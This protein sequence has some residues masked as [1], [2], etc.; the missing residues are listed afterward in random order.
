M[1]SSRIRLAIIGIGSSGARV[2]L[3]AFA[4]FPDVDVL[5]VVAPDESGEGTA[6][7]AYG[8]ERVETDAECLVNDPGNLDAVVIATPDDTHRDLVPLE[9]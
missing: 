3:T 6:A 8:V 4:S 1:T 2:H 9:I 5:A 7:N